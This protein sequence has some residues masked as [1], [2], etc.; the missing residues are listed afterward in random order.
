MTGARNGRRY[1]LR[2]CAMVTTPSSPPQIIEFGRADV[3]A[4]GQKIA[5]VDKP[6]S[7]L[8]RP[9]GHLSRPEDVAGITHD[10]VQGRPTCGWA[11]LKAA[12]WSP[13][14][15][16]VLVAHDASKAKMLLP[17]TTHLSLPWVCTYKVARQ[18]WPWAPGFALDELVEWRGLRKECKPAAP[19]CDRAA[20]RARDTAVLLGKFIESG[21]T[22]NQMLL[23]SAVITAPLSPPPLPDDE[24][25]WGLVPDDD[26]HWFARQAINLP[27]YVRQRASKE[28]ARRAA[29]GAE[30]DIRFE[31][32][33]LPD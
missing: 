6:M 32:Q 11:A 2:A 14:P 9:T 30:R 25:G 26:L 27:T 21:V 29:H 31:P 5:A 18:L 19:H 28:K 8:Y 10:D 33:V 16:D 22:L 1:R 20:T 7:A 24:S 23:M 17:P 12:I 15:P 13:V 4:E 3:E